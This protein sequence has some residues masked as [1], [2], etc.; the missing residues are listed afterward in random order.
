M[1]DKEIVR[2]ITL[3]DRR[4]V[5]M[6]SGIDWKPEYG[7]ELEAIDQELALL[8]PLVDQGH[9]ARQMCSL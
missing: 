2:Y 4:L 6:T 7:I 1:T 8:R 3:V 5:I 9:R